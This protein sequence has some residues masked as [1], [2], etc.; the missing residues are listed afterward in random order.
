MD[1]SIRCELPA[2][3]NHK[4]ENV[5]RVL[6]P[7][8]TRDEWPRQAPLGVLVRRIAILD[9]ETTGLDADQD[10]IIE[11]CVAMALVDARG[12]IVGIQSIGSALESPGYPLDPAIVKL[13]GLTDADLTGQGIDRERLAAFIE[14]C[15]GVVAFNAQFDRP[16]VERLL[17][18][19]DSRPWGCAMRDVPWHDL[20][21]EPG[22]QNYLLMQALRY[23]PAAHRAKDDVLSLVELLDHVCRDGESVM[24]KVLSA[25]AAPAY[26]FEASTATYSYRHDLK[27]RGYRW[28][29]T[30]SHQLWH[31]T[32]PQAEFRAEYRWYRQTIGKRPVVVEVPATERFRSERSWK[33][34]PPKVQVAPWRR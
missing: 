11:I 1:H 12:R 21:F 8:R 32:V 26:R 14:H 3:Q 19:M 2:R 25:M 33:P 23:N 31:K 13:T 20:G 10:Q 34:T 22:P 29:P 9:T 27:R 16:F 7:I 17:P 6:M 24:A 30:K 15:D 18:Q 5:E 4:L 28:A